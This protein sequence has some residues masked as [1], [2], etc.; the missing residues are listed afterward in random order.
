MERAGARL[1]LHGLMGI[2]C[3]SAATSQMDRRGRAWFTTP[4][5][6]LVMLIARLCFSCHVSRRCVREICVAP[7]HPH[8]LM[9]PCDTLAM[10]IYTRISHWISGFFKLKL[11]EAA[12][13]DAIPNLR[14]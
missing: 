3:G 11:I 4:S 9:L 14:F 6:L 5:L 13:G 12:R 8:A 10:K 2:H 1:C 7:S